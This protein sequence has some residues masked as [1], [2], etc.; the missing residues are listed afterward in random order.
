MLVQVLAG[1][2]KVE[3][4]MEKEGP[5]RVGLDIRGVGQSTVCSGRP[6]P[7]VTSARVPV[8]GRR[9]GLLPWP[10]DQLTVLTWSRGGCKGYRSS[11]RGRQRRGGDRRRALSQ[12]QPEPDSSGRVEVEC[13]GLDL[14]LGPFFHL[15]MRHSSSSRCHPSAPDRVH[16]CTMAM[17]SSVK[18]GWVHCHRMPSNDRRGTGNGGGTITR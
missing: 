3:A 5:G 14:T 16:G 1:Q 12:R 9:G 13:L 8:V 15:E 7:P 10:W 11:R 6:G 2:V 4:V 18:M 17:S